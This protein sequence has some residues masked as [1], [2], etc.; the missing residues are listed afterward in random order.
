MLT[1]ALGLAPGI[2][3]QV[4]ARLLKVFILAEQSHM[5]GHTNISTQES[6]SFH[7]VCFV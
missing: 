3:S 6:C 4:S 7:I 5:Q 2:T 1:V